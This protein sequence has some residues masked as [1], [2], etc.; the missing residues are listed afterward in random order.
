MSALT[1]TLSR[2]RARG[3]NGRHVVQGH[4][5]EALPRPLAGEGGGEG[6]A[7]AQP[8]DNR[9]HCNPAMRGDSESRSSVPTSP[10][11]FVI[12]AA[13]RASACTPRCRKCCIRW[14]DALVAHVL[15]TAR[16]LAPARVVLVVGH[17]G[18]AVQ[19]A[20]AGARLAFVAGAATRHRRRGARRGRRTAD[21]GV[22]LVA[23]G[24]V[25]SPAATFAALAD[26]AATASWRC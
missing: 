8:G 20:L 26:V 22:T 13:G 7:K 9:Y 17:G 16:T 24:D 3:R 10:I 2:T 25:R 4:H 11:Q 23:N 21:D 18:D 5:T 12:L 19:A 6:A 14:P 1:P 15:D